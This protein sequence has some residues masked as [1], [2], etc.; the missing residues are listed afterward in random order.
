MLKST[1]YLVQQVGRQLGL[2]QAQIDKLLKNDHVHEFEIELSS[3]KRLPAYRVQHNNRLGPYKGGVRFHPEVQLDEV[4]AL[5]LLMSLKTAAVGLPLGGGK[6][7]VRVN[8]KVLSKSE[9]EELSRA[10]VKGLATN[11]GPDQDIPAPDVNTD[12]QVIDWM[13][14]EYAKIS[15][16]QSGASFTGKS[17]AKGGSQ[18][19]EAATGRGGVAILKEYL[20]L[21]KRSASLDYAVQGFGNVGSYFALIAEQEQPKWKLKA[22]S[23]SS[24]TLV[25]DNGLS[26]KRLAKFKS[27]G[28][29]FV[30]FSELG[31]EVMPA[32]AIL[33][34]PVDVLVLAALGGA[35]TSKN[36][37][38]LNS[39]LIM[40]LANGPIDDEAGEILDN[41]G[42]AILP[43]IIANSGGVIVSYLEW[44]QNTN[45]QKWSEA[46][47]NLRLEEYLRPAIDATYNLSTAKSVSLKEAALMLAIKKLT[48]RT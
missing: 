34:Q 47:V 45:H 26:A 46:Q 7:G 44:L 35:I 16:D 3:G 29:N 30:Q 21:S 38:Q 48:T 19:R 40:E 43:D 25:S 37:N 33:N 18:G 10:Y 22:A 13:V 42:V 23:D 1:Q 27:A 36:V 20:R 31:I 6:G 28:H 14:D 15:G 2:N 9:L 8:P 17:L 24:A 41:N 4:K 11:I 12:A 32:E 39:N 5:A